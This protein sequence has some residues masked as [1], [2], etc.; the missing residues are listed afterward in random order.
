MN[1]DNP[2]EHGTQHPENSV[3]E[4]QLVDLAKQAPSKEVTAQKVKSL[5]RGHPALKRRRTQQF[6]A[7][8]V[9]HI[10]DESE[11]E[12]KHGRLGR[13]AREVG[14]AIDDA[15]NEWSEVVTSVKID[16][17]A[18]HEAAQQI[19]VILEDLEQAV[20]FSLGSSSENHHMQPRKIIQQLK[21]AR[22][23][24]RKI[25]LTAGQLRWVPDQAE[26]A[27]NKLLVDVAVFD[28]M[29]DD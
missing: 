1:Q 18:I 13:E 14:A 5:G 29:F 21:L 17:P 11:L 28:R 15:G 26:V 24:C 23:S 10:L 3:E 9:S 6:E 20:Q 4:C 27:F 2:L 16:I 22:V 25:C 19:M 12:Q 7:Q 8:T